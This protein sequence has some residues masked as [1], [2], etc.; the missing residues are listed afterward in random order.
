ME[1]VVSH[2]RIVGKVRH[3]VGVHGAS[4]IGVVGMVVGAESQEGLESGQKLLQTKLI[5][6]NNDEKQ[7][8][9]NINEEKENKL[10]SNDQGG[11]LWVFAV[12]PPEHQVIVCYDQRD[13]F[14]QMPFGDFSREGLIGVEFG[15]K[16]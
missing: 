11:S 2:S 1:V 10:C 13:R 9:S 14:Q 3:V 5:S 15:M 4:G 7:V 6:N 12:G 16:I 8:L